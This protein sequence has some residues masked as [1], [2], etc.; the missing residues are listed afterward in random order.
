MV[1]GRS[2]KVV[3]DGGSWSEGDDPRPRDEGREGFV[4]QVVALRPDGMV[5]MILLVSWSIALGFS[6]MTWPTMIGCCTTEGL[7]S[8]EMAPTIPEP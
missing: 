4:G 6:C 5:G 7:D 1:E 2:R 3:H 8:T